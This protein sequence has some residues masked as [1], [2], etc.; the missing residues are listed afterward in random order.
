[1]YRVCV[2]KFRS[3]DH[4]GNVQIAVGTLWRPNANGFVGKANMQG[5]TVG[6]GENRDRLN[7]QLFTRENDPEGYFSAIGDKYFSEHRCV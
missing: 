2:Q 7:A 6:L 4:V 1:M 3:A 5:M